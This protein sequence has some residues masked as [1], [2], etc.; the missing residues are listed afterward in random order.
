[1]CLHDDACKD[2]VLNTWNSYFYLSPSFRIFYKL[3]KLQTT[4]KKWNKETFG[5]VENHIKQLE[6]KLS[7]AQ[8]EISLQKE[9]GA[10]WHF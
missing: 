6:D 10:H 9:F 1:M 5:H 7:L 8:N 3:G 2:V 4:L